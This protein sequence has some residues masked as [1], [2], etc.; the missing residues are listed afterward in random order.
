MLPGGAFAGHPGE[1]LRAALLAN[2]NLGGDNCNRGMLL[3][4][5]LGAVLG[6]S[7]IPAD[8]VEG[9]VRGEEVLA[10][11]GKFSGLCAQAAASSPSS[12]LKGRL[13]RPYICPLLSS[14]TGRLGPLLAPRD[15]REKVGTLQRMAS[16]LG[17]EGEGVHTL[18][19]FRHLHSG[20]LSRVPVAF[21]V[22]SGAGAALILKPHYLFTG[23]PEPRMK[24]LEEGVAVR[25]RLEALGVSAAAG[26]SGSSSGS[27]AVT[28][29]ESAT[30]ASPRTY[31]TSAQFEQV[32]RSVDDV[33]HSG[34]WARA[35]Q[36]EPG[37]GVF[38]YPHPVEL[39]HNRL[40]NPVFGGMEGGLL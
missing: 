3:G 30:A 17:G 8:L 34:W 21:S 5:V 38:F 15:F 11:L 33:V 26:G 2:A 9:L 19:F 7:G 35:S 36:A 31:P 28:L 39:W 16:A 1:A 29:A 37:T 23:E 24:R 13:G 6:R 4:S 14:P 25:D 40:K 20:G 18:R 12:A 22:A 27:H 32:L 10:S